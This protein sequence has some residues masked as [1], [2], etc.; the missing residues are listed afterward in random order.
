MRRLVPLLFL[1]ACEGVDRVSENYLLWDVEGAQWVYRVVE[2]VFPKDTF[3]LRRLGTEDTSFAPETADV[4]LDWEGR[5]EY[6][7]WRGDRLDKFTDFSVWPGG[8]EVPLEQTFTLYML[9]PPVLGNWWADT[10]RGKAFS[11]EDTIPYVHWIE[12]RVAPQLE[13]ISWA[14]GAERCYRVELAEGLEAG[15][16]RVHLRKTLWLAGGLG[17]VRVQ[18][19]PDTFWLGDSSWVEDYLL[20]ELLELR[21]P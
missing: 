21:L 16:V 12:G 13:E 2:G 10:V 20:L 9:Y 15:S 17:P 1:L 5:R 8:E 3:V 11:G 19:G 14:G 7:S 18:L 4:C 6:I